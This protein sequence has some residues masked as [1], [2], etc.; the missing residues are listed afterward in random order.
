MF[1]LPLDSIAERTNLSVQRDA[2]LMELIAL[3]EANQKGVVVILDGTRPVG[4][5]TERDIVELLYHG[6]NLTGKAASIS[7][8]NVI[9][10]MGSRTIGYALNLMLEN[11]I[12]RIVVTDSSGAFVGVITQQD[13][14]SYL[15]EDFYRSTIKV[16][17]ILEKLGYLISVGPEASLQDVLRT[18]VIHRISAVV[19]VSNGKAEGIITEKDILK[20]AS[21]QSS[22]QNSVSGHMSSPVSTAPLTMSLV[23]IVRIMNDRAIR[24]IVIVNDEGH[25]IN[26]VTIR[27]VL[28]NLEGDYSKFLERKLKNAKDV[29]NMLPEILIEVTDMDSEQ[30]IIWANEKAISRFGRDIL[31]KPVTEFISRETWENINSS[32][33]NHSKREN[34]KLK[35]DNSIYELSGCFIQTEGKIEHGRFQLIM[36]DITEEVLLSTAD[37]LTAIYNRRFIN[38]FLMKEIEKSSRHGRKFSIVMC[39]LDNFKQIND[40]HGHLAGDIVLKSVADIIISSIRICDVAGRYGGD[41]FVIILPETPGEGAAV[42]MDKLRQQI[43]SAVIL[44]S[45]GAPIGITASFGIAVFPDNG[46]SPDD[47]LIASDSGLYRAKSLG[48]NRVAS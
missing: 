8:K 42:V 5:V 18:M 2:S 12:R 28:K 13:L 33:K 24:R 32:L 47:L 34:I 35:K 31:D 4:V 30:L 16:K 7:S 45:S 26:I 41:E 44:S 6:A 25:A 48:K 17:H 11:G 39:D 9:S 37:P 21:R 10:T 29:L 14:L 43:G 15:E 36:R 19:V 40:I 27:D 3:M 38:E 23:D 46:T 22:L 20:I 1:N